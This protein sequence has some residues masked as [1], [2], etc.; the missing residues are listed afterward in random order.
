M[1]TTR[2]A[3]LAASVGALPALAAVPAPGDQPPAAAI[4]HDSL[5]LVIHSFPVRSV[6]DRDRRA[7]D[8][9]SDPIRFLDHARSLGARGVQVGVGARDEAGARTLRDRAEAASMFLEGIVSLPRD[10][11]DLGR[12]EAEIRTAKQA[13]IAVVRTVMLSGRRYETFATIA[14]FR[15]FAEASAIALGLAAPVVARHDIL[16]AVENHKDWRADELL[17]ILKRNG[18][19]HVG[20]CLDTGN[21][22]ALLEDPMEVVEAL[23]PRAFTTHFKDMGLEEY[24]EGFLLAEVPL[25]A[26]VLDLPRVVRILRS[27]RPGIRFNVE[28]ITRDPLKVPCLTDRYWMTFADLPGRHLARSLALVRDHPPSR[29]LPRIGQMPRDEQLR[30]EDENIRHCLAFARDRL[31]L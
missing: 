5:G 30:A 14:A 7:A 11:A 3:M 13:G 4:G 15:R 17:A 25:G 8:R 26:G 9:F 10:A 24:R 21:S 6:G 23:A 31:G 27:A 22:I 12:F 19:D 18:N 16:L 28:M 29:P 1:Q 2:R 20:V